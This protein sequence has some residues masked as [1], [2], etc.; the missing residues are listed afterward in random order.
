M[1]RYGYFVVGDD[2]PKSVWVGE[3][4]VLQEGKANVQIFSN[5]ELNAVINV[6]PGCAVQQLSGEEQQ[7]APTFHIPGVRRP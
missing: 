1:P 5:G 7:P 2:K 4:M 3:A 6:A